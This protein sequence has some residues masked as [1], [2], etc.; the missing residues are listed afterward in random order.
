M[1]VQ[2]AHV[3]GGG[4]TARFAWLG[5]EVANVNLERFRASDLAGDASDQQIRYE[6][7]VERSGA[8]R[9]EVGLPDRGKGFAQGAAAARDYVQAL[10][11]NWSLC[12]ARFPVNNAAVR[13]FSLQPDVGKSGRID[14]A[15]DGQ[16]FARN[17]YCLREVMCEV[18]EGRQKQ[19]AEAVAAQ[20]VARGKAVVE[21]LSEET[22]V[23]SQRHHAVAD[24]AR[25]ENSEVA[26][27]TAGASPL[28]SHRDNRG[29][30]EDLCLATEG[31]GDSRKVSL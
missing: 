31:I 22:F 11:G 19:I 9:D 30:S 15:S 10:D 16:D 1:L 18:G 3:V 2:G 25:R 14:F 5:H 13:L 8:D 24:V 17:P 29:Q 7:C 4:V 23:F 6:R 26:P 20:A 21:E 12:D 27:Q 28:V